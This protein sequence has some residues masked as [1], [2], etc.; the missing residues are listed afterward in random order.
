M[1]KDRMVDTAGMMNLIELD[2]LEWKMAKKDFGET[3]NI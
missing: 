2:D 1:S 3:Y